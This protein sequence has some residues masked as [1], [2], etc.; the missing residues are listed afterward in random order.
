MKGTV[1]KEERR[2]HQRNYSKAKNQNWQQHSLYL[3]LTTNPDKENKIE[4]SNREDI[5]FSLVKIRQTAIWQLFRGAKFN[6]ESLC[7]IHFFTFM[8]ARIIC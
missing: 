3:L 1:T 8:V 5:L 4:K 7:K 2:N 6:F